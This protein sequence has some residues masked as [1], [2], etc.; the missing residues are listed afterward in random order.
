MDPRSPGE[1]HQRIELDKD[2]WVPPQVQ[3]L[4]PRDGRRE[5]E[6]QE[7]RPVNPYPDR[8]A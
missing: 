8:P 5:P 7:V 2:F 3:I 1:E 6:D 4:L